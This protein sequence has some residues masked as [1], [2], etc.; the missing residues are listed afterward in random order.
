MEF[1]L[2]PVVLSSLVALHKAKTLVSVTDSFAVFGK[3]YSQVLA[4]SNFAEIEKAA[5]GDGKMHWKDADPEKQIEAGFYAG[6]LP[7]APVEAAPA[8]EATPEA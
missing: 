8:G 6:A 2:D 1:T 7:A 4:Q 5:T 3:E